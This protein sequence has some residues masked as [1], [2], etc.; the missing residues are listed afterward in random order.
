MQFRGR[1][2]RSR[3]ELKVSRP[4]SEG[5]CRVEV[6]VDLPTG[7]W[8]AVHNCLQGGDIARLADWL[9][10]AGDS[11]PTSIDFLEPELSFETH[12]D[13]GLWLRVRL[14][15]NLCPAWVK[16]PDQEFTVEY[17]IT[18]DSLRRAAAALREE[19]RRAGSD[20]RI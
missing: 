11:P 18:P 20:G 3:F 1:E 12:E 10:A 14:R 5:W 8:S 15:Y 4:D 9:E 19:F 13:E 17:P 16:D 2:A 6:T 7:R